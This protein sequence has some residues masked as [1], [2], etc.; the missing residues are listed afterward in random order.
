MTYASSGP[1]F[2]AVAPVQGVSGPS[3]QNQNRMRLALD[4]DEV[5][6]LGAQVIPVFGQQPVGHRGQQRTS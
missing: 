6:V 1:V 4:D 5:A 2:V 3:G